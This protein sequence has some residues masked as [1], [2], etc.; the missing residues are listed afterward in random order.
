MSQ[1]SW[2]YKALTGSHI[3]KVSGGRLKRF[4][5]KQAAGMIGSWIIETG[6]PN[7]V[8][9][10]VVEIGNG[11]AG[12]GLSQYTGVRRRAYDRARASA[13][14]NG[15]NVNSKEW[16]FKYFVD[17][18][19]GKHDTNGASLVGWTRS[20]ERAPEFNS[21]A[22]YAQYYTDTYFRPGVPHM[23][24]RR[25]YADETFTTIGSQPETPVTNPNQIKNPQ[26]GINPGIP[27]GPGELIGDALRALGLPF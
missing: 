16:Q 9:L 7:L 27:K 2:F 25:S 22:D 20:F 1:R 14:R 15:Q 6:D 4:T 17:E 10:D 19:L 12:R 3:E 26:Q 8:N 23:D 13:L 21:A 5:P 24:R 18:Y 11:N